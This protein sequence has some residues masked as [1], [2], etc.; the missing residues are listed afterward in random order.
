MKKIWKLLLYAL[1]GILGVWLTA[2]FLL[3]IGL[4]FLLGWGVSRLA[5][6]LERRL[7]KRVPL[8]AFLSA[9]LMARPRAAGRTG[10]A[11]KK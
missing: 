8:A 11:A 7:K 3:P 10:K 6:P 9:G 4:P 2:K 5:L 1:G